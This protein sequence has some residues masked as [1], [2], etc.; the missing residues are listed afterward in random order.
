MLLPA[1]CCVV[2]GACRPLP[3]ASRRRAQEASSAAREKGG[4]SSF[5]G[6]FPRSFTDCPG[7]S[8]INWDALP[9]AQPAT[10][11]WDLELDNQ[12]ALDQPP[13]MGRLAEL[14]GGPPMLLPAGRPAGRREG[15]REGEEE[16]E[17]GRSAQVSTTSKH[18]V[19]AAVHHSPSTMRPPPSPAARE[20]PTRH[21]PQMV[22]TPRPHIHTTP[23]TTTP[24]Q[25]VDAPE[26]GGG[27]GRHGRRP[28]RLAFGR[29]GHPSTAGRTEEPRAASA[30]QGRAVQ[31]K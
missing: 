2:R 15:G 5:P 28:S 21:S 11:L 17:L 31:C 30:P 8:T 9:A 1:A 19:S 25:T 26:Y 29:R 6:N 12:H 24:H 16:R 18:S 27:H 10:T 7:P 14:A 3:A 23:H 20:A 13:T 4:V 22:W